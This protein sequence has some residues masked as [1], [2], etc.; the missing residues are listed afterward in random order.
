LEQ[1]ENALRLLALSRA[2]FMSLATRWRPIKPCSAQLLMDP[3]G[4]LEAAVLHEHC[5]DSVV[6]TAFSAARFPGASRRCRQ[7]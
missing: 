3:L 4:S 6:I 7:A 2:W 5:L 1:G